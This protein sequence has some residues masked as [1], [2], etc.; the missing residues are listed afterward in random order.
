MPVRSDNRNVMLQSNLLKKTP[1]V[2]CFRLKFIY[3]V[4]DT[5][6]ELSITDRV[7]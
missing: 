6:I 4:A 1:V 3:R 2:R 7:P 5:L